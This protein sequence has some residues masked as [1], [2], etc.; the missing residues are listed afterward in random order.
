ML[1]EIASTSISEISF[2]EPARATSDTPLID[3]VARMRGRRRGAAIIEDDGRLAG[4]FTERDLMLRVE[5]SNQDW[6]KK[7]VSEVM[8]RDVIV[9]K[10]SDSISAA[11]QKMKE[12]LFRHL[13]VDR[14]PE[15]PTALIS[16]RD[17]LSYIAEYFPKEF[18]NLPPDPEHEASQPWGG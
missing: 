10:A 11:V 9:I 6:H 18:Q 14:G 5:H 17:I 2:R 13:P 1:E 3:V 8:T 4:I 16:I 7:P 15:K 12:G